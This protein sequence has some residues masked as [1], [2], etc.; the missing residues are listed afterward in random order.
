MASFPLS[1]VSF[2][3]K[4]NGDSVQASHIDDLQDEVHAI[5]D[6]YINGTAHLKSSNSTVANLSVSGN[7]TIVGSISATGQGK[8]ALQQNST[9][10]LAN[11]TWTGINF[12]TENFD[13]GSMHST[14]VNSSRVV[15]N[16]S[17]TGYYEFTGAVAFNA[18]N[19]TGIC[20]I[21]IQ[22]NDTTDISARIFAPLGN[23]NAQGPTLI[24]T[25]QAQITSATDYVGL[26]AFQGSGSTLSLSEPHMVFYARKLV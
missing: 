1:V 7:C 20:S 19:S 15:F 10:S 12:D 25:C 9:F 4:N 23:F 22:K 24:V 13:I 17:G 11:N 26:F 14:A 21:R 5:E 2:T 8:C 3:S 16:T 6:G 18:S